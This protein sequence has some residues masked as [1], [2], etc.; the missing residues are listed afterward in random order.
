MDINGVEASL[1][2][3]NYPRFCGQI[4]LEAKDKELALLCVQAYNDWM[5]EEWCRDSGGRLIPLCLVPLWDS[6]LAAREVER[7]AARGVR[8][9]AFSEIPPWL[10]L[11]SF[12]SGYWDP[13][14]GACEETRT[15][16]CMHVGSGTRTVLTSE[17][18][19]PAVGVLMLFANSAASMSD[20]LMSGLLARFPELRIMYAECQIG[21]IPYVLQRADEIWIEHRWARDASL[22]ELPSTYYRDRIYSCFFRDAV[23]IEMLSHIG[24]S[25]V[26]FETDYPHNDGTWPDSQ[27]VA[28]QLL[29]DLEPEVVSKIC[30][31]NA[32]DLFG[33]PLNRS[34][35]AI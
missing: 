25:Q 26:L 12:H 8:A 23:G 19:V 6:H 30:R 31:T 34:T 35:A 2:F 7:N 16:V 14:L 27:K 4:F 29:G 3:P 1:C 24:E 17:D 13:F 15:V 18:A 22:A 10:G 9:V 11:P 21:W 20:I 33:L 5:V 32:I 28:S